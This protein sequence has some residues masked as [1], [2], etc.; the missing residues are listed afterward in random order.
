[1]TRDEIPVALQAYVQQ[2]FAQV[3]K[4]AGTAKAKTD[5]KQ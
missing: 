3:R 1:V 4:A 2:Y 5:A